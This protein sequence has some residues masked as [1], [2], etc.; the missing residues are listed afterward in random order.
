MRAFTPRGMKATRKKHPRYM[1]MS[2]TSF[3]RIL[4]FEYPVLRPPFPE[5][6]VRKFS[7][8]RGSN[9]ART[10]F[11]SPRGFYCRYKRRREMAIR[12]IG[13]KAKDEFEHNSFVP[14]WTFILRVCT[15]LLHPA[16]VALY[17]EEEEEEKVWK[18][19]VLGP[20]W[21]PINGGK[22][23]LGSTICSR[24]QGR[25]EAE[26]RCAEVAPWSR[27]EDRPMGVLI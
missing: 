5:I 4:A 16:L 20:K 15:K 9:R 18:F 25:R 17:V 27:L 7:R 1:Q 11:A 10:T 22:W 26:S 14:F 2:V 3:H 23:S 12:K 13:S 24:G 19:V 21:W 6:V 8:R